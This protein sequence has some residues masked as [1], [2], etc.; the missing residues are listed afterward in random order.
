[1]LKKFL[2]FALTCFATLALFACDDDTNS[3]QVVEQDPSQSSMESS[4]S[5]A[6]EISSSSLEASAECSSS[7][8]LPLQDTTAEK[9]HFDK[10]PFDTTGVEPDIYHYGPLL[11]DED[12]TYFKEIFGEK[13]KDAFWVQ[14]EDDGYCYTID[15]PEGE[16]GGGYITNGPYQY[17][18][19][20]QNDS[21]LFTDYQYCS[22]YEWGD[23]HR[24]EY[25]YSQK[26]TVGADTFY[27]G[28]YESLLILNKL[29]DST[30]TQWT[31]KNPSYVPPAQDT[32]IH[33][34]KKSWFEDDSMVTFVGANPNSDYVDTIFI[35]KYNLKITDFE[36]TWIFENETCTKLGYKAAPGITPAESCRAFIEH[37]NEGAKCIQRVMGLSRYKFARLCR[38]E[39]HRY[40]QSDVWCIL[41][42]EKPTE[43]SED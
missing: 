43:L 25:A 21:L 9:T 23:C 2:S 34:W 19:I 42:S 27:Y 30:I 17:I 8:E 33:G 12:S 4:S 7:E 35:E 18:I 5:E 14:P 20:E 24:D 10:L 29:T 38:P 36:K 6:S 32:T 41:D 26:I 40:R 11:E 39:P 28:V 37:Y 15:E 16:L 1:M 3:I 13:V 22:T 31:V